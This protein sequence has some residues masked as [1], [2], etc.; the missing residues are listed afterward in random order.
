MKKKIKKAAEKYSH[1]AIE[2]NTAFKTHKNDFI[3][4][5][6]SKV[7]KNYWYKKFKAEIV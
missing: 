5:V 7:A 1:G 6:K 4:G 2:F 3:E